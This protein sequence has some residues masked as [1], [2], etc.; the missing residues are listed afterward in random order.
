[1][2]EKCQFLASNLCQFMNG[3]H[4]GNLCQSGVNASYQQHR[5][6]VES[7]VMFSSEDLFH[8]YV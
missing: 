2:W 7:L 6:L 4:G 8:G 3:K 1:M 5:G